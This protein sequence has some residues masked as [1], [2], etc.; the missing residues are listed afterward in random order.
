[1]TWQRL[2]DAEANDMALRDAQWERSIRGTSAIALDIDYYAY[3]RITK[4]D[5]TLSIWDHYFTDHYEPT[6]TIGLWFKYA[7]RIE[8]T[9]FTHER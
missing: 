4:G 7:D 6:A 9:G 5:E 1:M 2:T 8:I 3:P